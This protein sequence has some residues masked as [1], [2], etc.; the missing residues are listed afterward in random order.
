M[1]IQEAQDKTRICLSVKEGLTFH[2]SIKVCKN[3]TIQM[4]SLGLLVACF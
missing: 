1:N 3:V 4:T 2:F